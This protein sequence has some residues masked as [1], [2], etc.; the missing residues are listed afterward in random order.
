MD[1]RRYSHGL[2]ATVRRGT[3]KPAPKQSTCHQEDG[4][5]NEEGNLSAT[6]D[7]TYEGCTAGVTPFA[8][9]HLSPKMVHE[10][11]MDYQA[12]EG[13]T[14]KTQA[15]NRKFLAGNKLGPPKD[16]NELIRV[17]NN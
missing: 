10:T 14:H 6:N 7:R 15:E 3:G 2:A 4:G 13:A 8:V 12:F 17:L 9:P 11:E 5:D 1:G 16:L